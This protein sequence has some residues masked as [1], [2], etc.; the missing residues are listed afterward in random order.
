MKIQI[1]AVALVSFLLCSCSEEGTTTDEAGS[2]QTPAVSES[3]EET[4]V[5][6]ISVQAASEK[7]KAGDDLKVLDIRTPGEFAEGH[8]A[9]A[10]NIDFKAPDFDEELAKL[11]QNKTYLVHCGS[12]GR[13]GMSLAKFRELGFKKIFHLNQGFMEWEAAGLPV[14]K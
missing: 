9:G 10:V 5:E 6:D 7:L 11:D 14:E 12:G 4:V 13:S 2:Q 8:I 3:A 1:T